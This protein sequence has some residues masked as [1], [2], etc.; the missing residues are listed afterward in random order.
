MFTTML[1]YSIQ[2]TAVWKNLNSKFQCH[3]SKFRWQDQIFADIW[4]RKI[5][6]DRFPSSSSRFKWYHSICLDRKSSISNCLTIKVDSW[7]VFKDLSFILF[8][9]SIP[10]WYSIQWIQIQ[11]LSLRYLLNLWVIEYWETN[12]IINI[13]IHLTWFIIISFILY[14]YDTCLINNWQIIISNPCPNTCNRSIYFILT[15]VLQGHEWE[16]EPDS[17]D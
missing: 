17:A 13:E 16:S 10:K 1:V 6:P 11:K 5:F 9:V 4:M 8:E 12:I 3:N 14:L 2:Y 15:T 7:C